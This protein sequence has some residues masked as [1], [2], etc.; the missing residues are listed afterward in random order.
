M[1][2]LDPAEVRRTEGSLVHHRFRQT[3]LGKEV[4]DEVH[5]WPYIRPSRAPGRLES[6]ISSR[7][8]VSASRCHTSGRRQR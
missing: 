7:T 2:D 3:S 5:R 1:P 4:I 8:G 6:M